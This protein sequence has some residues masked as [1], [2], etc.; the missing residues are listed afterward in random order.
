MRSASSQLATEIGQ[1]EDPQGA[2]GLTALLH[3][4]ELRFN[5]RSPVGNLTRSEIG[6]LGWSSLRKARVQEYDLASPT[7]AKT[8]AAVVWPTTGARAAA[9]DGRQRARALAP[10]RAVGQLVGRLRSPSLAAQALAGDGVES[11]TGRAEGDELLD[12]AR[13]GFGFLR[14][15]HAP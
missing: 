1:V 15:L 8:P 3:G 12:A 10:S 14:R 13:A 4:A 9:G 11:L 5:R 2:S 6:W 7:S